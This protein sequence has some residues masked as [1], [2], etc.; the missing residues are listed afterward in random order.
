MASHLNRLGR[1]IRPFK[2]ESLVLHL[3]V[4]EANISVTCC[5]NHVVQCTLC[6]SIY[7]SSPQSSMFYFPPNQCCSLNPYA[8]MFLIVSAFSQRPRFFEYSLKLYSVL[9]RS[10]R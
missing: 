10:T 9:F 1:I 8:Y 5:L 7:L 2:S 6:V 4:K 3:W